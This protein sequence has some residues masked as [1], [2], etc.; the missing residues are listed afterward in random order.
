[1]HDAGFVPI[2]PN[3][4]IVGNPV[5]G[6][7]MFFGR[8]AEFNLIR[9]RFE[10]TDRGSLLVF[11][12]ERRS[13]KTSILFQILDHRL[14]SE[15]I[16]VLIDMQS[17]AVAGEAEFLARLS[18]EILAALGP[19]A[20][21]IP[22]PVFGGE[23]ARSELFR[24]FVQRCLAAH[25]GKKLVLL[26]D[27]YELFENKI[28]AGLLSQ[29]VLNILATL[30]EHSPVYMIFT[31]SQHL[32]QRRR[33]YWSI[34]GKSIYKTVSYLE[35]DDA[36]SLIRQPVEGRLRYDDEAVEGIVR[37]TA[38][39]PFYTQAICQSLIDH[40]NDERTHHATVARV[41]EVVGGIVDNP[42]PQMVFRWDGLERDDKLVLALLAECLAAPE[43]HATA[44]DVL[45]H[46][47]RRAYPLELDRAR[48]ATTLEKLF[49]TELLLRSDRDGGPGYAFRMDLWRL[50]IRRQHSVWQVL[51]EEGLAIRKAAP[52]R[53]RIVAA[54]LGVAGVVALAIVPRL[55][56]GRRGADQVVAAGGPQGFV[57]VDVRP[58]GAVLRIDGR[59]AS[60]GSL[61]D[62]I[63]AGEHR[64]E[65]TAPG[66]AD[67]TLTGRVAPGDTLALALDLRARVGDLR[68]ETRPP[69]A[70]VS[71]DGRVVGRSPLT[72][73][74]LGVPTPHRVEAAR[75]GY[76]VARADV[77]LQPDATTTTSLALEA[78]RTD[79]VVTTDPGRSEIR[80]DG[81]P[82]GA[83]P[84][85]LTALALGRHV[86]RATRAGY[87]QVESTI[88]VT[89]ATRQVHLTLAPAPP[90]VLVVLGD[91]PAQIYV[92]G[93]LAV[94]NVQNSGP[95]PLPPG[96]HTVR[97]ILVSG[98]ILDHTVPVRSGERTIY[99]FSKN[100][101][102]HRTE[103]GR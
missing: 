29:D 61:R 58:D 54:G 100:V 49:K 55:M 56:L 68:V 92:D 2:S 101:V 98:E 13:G 42:L 7:A 4:Y 30:M 83:S 64:F 45:A 25:P 81:V 60:V 26:F 32:E 46:V 47:K 31:G 21:A 17:M 75:E 67:T 90:G 8:R 18:E 12:G 15:L 19:G 80:V 91:R 70:E 84:V 103:G 43:G 39:Q 27:E 89:A 69:G 62:S 24:R 11:C 95:R 6:R 44:D 79:V 14:G 10:H 86:I 23:A 72:V 63:A 35:R 57:I 53:G 76:G 96:D 28:D 38:G 87:T 1:M 77:T 40:L 9:K 52:S 71:V 22:K 50:W 36:V 48:V 85:T 97:V 99:D 74:G 65:L 5:R 41:A 94:E 66:Y 82:R 73:R 51:R 34:L 59:R 88:A 16:P 37:L 93:M 33:D 20:A 3:P 78:G 102:T